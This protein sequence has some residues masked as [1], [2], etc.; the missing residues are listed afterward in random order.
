MWSSRSEISRRVLPRGRSTGVSATL[1]Q[2]STVTTWTL[3]NA[4][5]ELTIRTGVAGRA[6]MG[7][8]LTLLMGRGAST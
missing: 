4:D 1:V 2:N 7:H 6:K 8:R 3:T 5:G